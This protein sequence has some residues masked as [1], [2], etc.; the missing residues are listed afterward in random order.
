MAAVV[1]DDAFELFAAMA[2]AMRAPSEFTGGA[3]AASEVLE[4]VDDELPDVL[5][6]PAGKPV[7]ARVV[8]SVP[9]GFNTSIAEKVSS[10]GARFGGPEC[11]AAET[12]G[13]DFTIP[14]APFRTALE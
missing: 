14:A 10:G 5:E 1:S 12:S 6:L 9:P 3:G 13:L 7:A 4:S 8:V 11:A 2:A